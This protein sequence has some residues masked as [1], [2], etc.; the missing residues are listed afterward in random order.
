[1]PVI[2]T[3]QATI[4]T[5]SGA[6]KP[7]LRMSFKSICRYAV[8]ISNGLKHLLHPEDRVTDSTKSTP[9]K[10]TGSQVIKTAPVAMSPHHAR[11]AWGQDE[12]IT[13]PSKR[14]SI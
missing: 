9:S 10:S 4:D 5:T 2:G 3:S 8:K 11:L 12:S 7:V 6:H 13:P 1:M 14:P